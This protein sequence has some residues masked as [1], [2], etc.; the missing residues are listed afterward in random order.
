MAPEQQSLPIKSVFFCYRRSDSEE[1]VDRVYETLEGDLS[2]EA[3]FRDIHDIEAG[4]D[5]TAVVQKRLTDCLVVLIF[6]GRD[7]ITVQ[8][9]DGRARLSDESD[10]VRLE[11]L[12]ALS[13]P[14]VRVIPVLVKRAEMP[15]EDVLPPELKQLSKLN[16]L[17]VGSGKEYRPDMA[18]LVKNIRSAAFESSRERAQ[19]AAAQ[20]AE[21]QRR[22]WDLDVAKAATGSTWDGGWKPLLDCIADGRAVVICGSGLGS[23]A[24]L[25]DPASREAGLAAEIAVA[26]NLPR[27]PPDEVRPLVQLAARC[28]ERGQRVHFIRA[29][30][31]AADRLTPASDLDALLSL[32]LTR[33]MTSALDSGLEASLQRLGRRV[34][35][36]SYAPARPFDLDRVELARGEPHDNTLVFHVAGSTR[37]GWGS[38]AVSDADWRRFADAWRER[39]RR[40]RSLS[41]L[42]GSRRSPIILG[43]GYPAGF[44]EFWL[45]L[46]LRMGSRE[47]FVGVSALSGD[48]SLTRFLREQAGR[49]DVHFRRIDDVERFNQELVRRWQ[50]LSRAE[51][52][53]GGLLQKDLIVDR[54]RHSVVVDALAGTQGSPQLSAFPGLR[55]F[56]EDD[57][58][59][60][61]GRDEEIGLLVQA[62]RSR[63]VSLLFAA[64]GAGKTSVLRAGLFPALC[65]LNFVPILL[66]IDWSSSSEAIRQQVVESVIARAA[67][68]EIAL[69]ELQVGSTIWAY[70]HRRDVTC[71]STTEGVSRF[72]L[73]IDQFEEF[74]TLGAKDA[75][76]LARTRQ[77]WTELSDAIEGRVPSDLAGLFDREPDAASIFDLDAPAPRVLLS[78]REDYLPQMDALRWEMPSLNMDGIR[79]R[80]LRRGVAIETLLATEPVVFSRDAAEALVDFASAGALPPSDTNGRAFGEVNPSMMSLL[81]NVMDQRRR[82]LGLKLVDERM[83]REDLFA[84]LLSSYESAFAGLRSATKRWV[85][86][87][88][89]TANGMRVAV[90]TEQAEADLAKR[91]V[92]AGELDSLIARRILLSSVRSGVRY[93]ELAHDFL[94]PSV[95]ASRA[96]RSSIPKWLGRFLRL[97][98]A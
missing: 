19:A 2:R 57:S 3:L 17:R 22:E 60:L 37:D 53:D 35:S 56:D 32:P 38:F 6:I 77:A 34:V 16:A 96:A 58:P 1:V 47:F 81:C 90:A 85:E 82:S 95:L 62:V 43:G 65:S 13:L 89:V 80:G 97:R 20:R 61:L 79:L 52:S 42:F 69:P 44:V 91:R 74:F 8:T 55:P 76:A 41:E 75:E 71:L 92:P 63:S 83:V 10:P 33:L 4:F 15:S 46:A 48:P 87:E 24:E 25:G 18:T 39:D 64:P 9:K 50:E 14:F 54:P 26:L 72:V 7:W 66:R 45:D 59:R 94:L 93:V 73:V 40:P 70:F 27:P 21:R 11:V 68:A 23:N 36:A 5:F 49:A 31:L 51:S 78:L 12:T 28:E 86:D 30:R 98:E 88:L 67:E 84:A 29:L